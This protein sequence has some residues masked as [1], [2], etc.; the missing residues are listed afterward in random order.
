MTAHTYLD[1]GVTILHA[2]L[3]TSA[4]QPQAAAQTTIHPFI[5]I[6]REACAGATTLG[7]HLIPLLD[8]QVGE[9][10]RSWMFLDKDL[11]THALTKHHLPEYLAQYLPEDRISEIKGM[12]G[13]LVGLH[14]PLWE[15]EQRV[16][17]AILQIAQL[18]CVIFAGRASHLITRALPG[19]LHLRLVASM[20]ARIKRMQELQNCTDTVAENALRSTDNARRRY[21]QTNF[22]RDINDPHTYD[23]IINTDHVA[24]ATAAHM[25]VRALHDRIGTPAATARP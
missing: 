23:L 25:V 4:A 12:I 11:I 8:E 15:L 24:P 9:E 16:S 10:G 2:R 18:G 5:T 14:P 7:L 19:G 6:S 20:E 17:E 1:Q 22:E 13:E 3:K 21:V